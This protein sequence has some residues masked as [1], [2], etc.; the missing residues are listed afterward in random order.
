MS[1]RF[2]ILPALLLGATIIPGSAQ[3]QKE[4]RPT[5]N[6]KSVELLHERSDGLSKLVL[7]GTNGRKHLLPDGTFRSES[8]AMIIV[9][10]GRITSVAAPRGE[11]VEVESVQLGR[12]GTISLIGTERTG[13]KIGESSIGPIS[14][15]KYTTREGAM[16]IIQNGA[17]TQASI[18]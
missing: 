14:D 4:G 12:G 16:I 3:A 2:S 10:D 17:I 1:K 7:I 18:E 8:G 5:I 6:V 13:I 11:R 9:L 15:G